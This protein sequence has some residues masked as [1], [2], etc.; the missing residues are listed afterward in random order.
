MDIDLLSR[1]VKELILDRDE[2]SLPGVGCFVAELVPSVF[3]DK[4]Y[5]IHPPYRRL[6]F[7][8]RQDGADRS[9]AELYAASN[10]V[11]Q[12]DADRIIHDF[13]AEMKEVLQQKKTIVFPGLGRLRAT[14]ENNFFFVADEDLD[15]YPAGFGL[16]PVSLK[17]HEETTEEVSQALD[18]F[19]AIIEADS[20][21]SG[22][23]GSAPDNTPAMN[24]EP[25]AAVEAASEIAPVA[26]FADEAVSETAG[27]AGFATEAASD[28]GSRKEEYARPEAAQEQAPDVEAPAAQETE[29]PLEPAVGLDSIVN[30]EQEV[31]TEQEIG[32]EQV[33]NPEQEIGTEQ[34]VGTETGGPLATEK[35]DTET[36][37]A[38]NA[39]TEETSSVKIPEEEIT[40]SV[41]TPAEQAPKAGRKTALWIILT[42]LII[43][44]VALIAFAVTGRIAPDLVD[45]ILYSP[46]EL[47]ILHDNF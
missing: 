23:A 38:E 25:S 30:P 6:Y 31:G 37:T 18:G 9:L 20:D 43:A 28:Q 11:E 7:R 8:Q 12:A 47:D 46:E 42:I 39:I 22:G 34:E 14:R 13:L 45:P 5:T 44:L 26:G 41:E 36:V 10:G 35:T 21:I 1:M 40:P 15:I 24:V 27:V 16:E 2:V 17:T 19:K 29:L 3:S 33:V 4:G 32:T